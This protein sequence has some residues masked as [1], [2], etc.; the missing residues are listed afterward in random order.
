MISARIIAHLS[1]WRAQQCL[2]ILTE[3]LVSF[4]ALFLLE[5]GM[6]VESV[7]VTFAT[8]YILAALLI[9]IHRQHILPTAF[10]ALLP[11]GLGAL[12]IVGALAALLS[13]YPI[14][15]A[16]AS[17]GVLT[18]KD[19]ATT[20]AMGEIHHAAEKSGIE[21]S[22]LISIGM[23]LGALLLMV[24]LA[25][26]GQI[27]LVAPQIWIG[28]IATLCGAL[29]FMLLRGR[30]RIK[31]FTAP[32]SIP[33]RVRLTCALSLIYNA[34]SFT[35]KR[36]VVPIAVAQMARELDLGADAYSTLG[37]ILS[38]LVLLGLS[39]RGVSFSG[40][41]SRA[42]MYLGY[43][44]GLFLWILLANIASSA[45]GGLPGAIA[46]LICLFLI[47]ITAKIWTLGFIETLRLEARNTDTAS[48]ES[49][50][51]SYFMEMKG[52][53]AGS[54]FLV[55]IA[56][57]WAGFPPLFPAACLGLGLGYFIMT[58]TVSQALA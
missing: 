51:F 2:L 27:L 20:D 36:F 30:I 55:A 12:A 56:G 58:R 19:M 33:K 14:S 5:Q 34:T 29:F 28:L 37:A 54:G 43:F 32:T 11:I 48:A 49:A 4:L 3:V 46:A 41:S 38:L 17:L 26:T 23:L 45:W 1:A 9:R 40:F 22:R 13:P 16:I 24:A 52:Y 39:L 47:E 42:M 44:S 10:A 31:S 8:L 25:G 57:L 7:L 53:G 15:L 21:P 35:G 50:Y 6:K 18:L